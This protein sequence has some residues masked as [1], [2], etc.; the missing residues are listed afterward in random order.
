MLQS[1][2]SKLF[3]A[4]R[5]GAE[6]PAGLD[7]MGLLEAIVCETQTAALHAAVIASALTALQSGGHMRGPQALKDFV[8][9]QSAVIG[10]LLRSHEEA[11]LD[12]AA[13]LKVKALFSEL[14]SARGGMD[15]LIADAG[16][17]GAE[18]SSF[19]YNPTLAQW[20]KV[21]QRALDA[22]TA[23]DPSLRSGLPEYYS[24][25]STMLAKLL[26]GTIEG[27]QPC[28]N[29][30]GQP[31]LP[32][33]PQRR[34]TARRSLLQQVML[35]YRGKTAPVIAKDISTTGLGLER[36]PD[37]KSQELVQIELN[38]GRRLIGLVVWTKDG[39]AGVRL[40]KPLPP[41]D[42]LLIG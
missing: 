22:V 13:V 26:K 14:A 15:R 12:A 31:F 28:I 29:E 7:G 6:Q 35:R 8:P 36:A 20:S 30:A 38:G 40:G 16:R 32:D 34:R 39:S 18:Q 3:T 33:M 37:L 19:N 24:R 23:L 41:N 10:E 17:L 21:C 25:N 4:E 9:G 5:P 42:P 27:R 2:R 11:G 1:L